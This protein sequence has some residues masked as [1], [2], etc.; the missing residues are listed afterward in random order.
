MSVF[1]IAEAGVNHN[2]SIDLAK[3]LIDAAADA[4]ADAVKFQTFI[5]EKVIST[6]AE[7]ADYQKESTGASES[8][9]D[10][11]RKL[12]LSYDSFR[13]LKA[14]CEKKDILFLS[15]PFDLPSLDFLIS[16]GM[17]ILKIPSGEITN[18]P[19]LIA[20]AKTHLPVILST[21]MSRLE[22]ITYARSVLLENGTPEI[23]LLHC[24][25]EYPTPFCD[26]NI[27][28]MLT[29]KERFGGRVGYSDHTLGIEAPIAATALGAEVIEKHFT[30]DK[31][32]PGPD[33]SCSLEPNELK[34]MVS[35]IRN[36]EK[37]LGTGEKVP[38]SSET[39]N[40]AIARKSI[41]AARDI[42][43]GEVF[44]SSN[45]DVKRPG[46]GISPMN[47]FSVLGKTAK[48]DFLADELIEL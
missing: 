17:P 32:M 45:L 22:E 28:A 5:P 12:W 14:Y 24:N 30:L 3:K 10:M 31:T 9:L 26:A 6:F 43:M 35:A 18:L 41:V 13:E 48:R 8:Q 7:K 23:T 39:R 36:I 37:A 47:W 16:L 11:V 2:G 42:K 44:T 40:I 20:A 19:L 21:G 25:T 27:K 34:A 4:H 29:L 15:T 1:I 33:H 46:N 38:S